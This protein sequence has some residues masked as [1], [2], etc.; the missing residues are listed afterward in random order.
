M[1]ILKAFVLDGTAHQVNILWKDGKPLFRASEI[2]AILELQNI[3]ATLKA[4]DADEKGIARVYTLGGEQD[5]AF[6]TEEGLYRLLMISRK[7]IARPFQKWVTKVLVAIRENGKYELEQAE[8]A[9]EGR[10]QQALVEEADK[11]KI[12]IDKVRHDALIDAFKGPNRYVVYFG[13][14]RAE[15]DGEILVKIGSSKDLKVRSETLADE[16]G[17]MS[18]FKVFDCPTNEMF[19]RCLQKHPMIKPFLFKDVIHNGR[20]SNEVFKVQPDFIETMVL[21]AKKSLKKFQT[22][23]SAEHEIELERLKVQ[24]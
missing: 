11:A 5:V 3:R 22:G 2:G 20:R 9:A 10:M 17:S 23:A 6:L 18:I 13:K 1:D 4:F 14:I 21:I 24:K 19:E 16:F 7:P 12:Q 15:S 8:R